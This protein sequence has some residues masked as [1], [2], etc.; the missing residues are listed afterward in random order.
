[1]TPDLDRIYLGDCVETMKTWPSGFVNTCVTSPPYWGL[2][3]YGVDGQRGSEPSPEEFVA[4][5]VD[6]FREV[7]RVLRDDGT[8]WLNIGD[9]YTD[10]GRGKD[11]GSTLDG[12][13]NNQSESRKIT[14]REKF[15]GLKPKNLVGIPW[16][17][18]FA[19]QADGWYLRSDIIWSKPNVMPE[20]A[21]DRPT[22]AHEYIF[23]LTKNEKYY[24]DQEAILEDCSPNT[25][26]R[27]SQNVEAQIGSARAN[28]GT[29]TN[30]NM[31]AVVRSA[32]ALKNSPGSKQNENFASHVCLKVE[33][34]NKR[35][36]WTVPPMPFKEAHFATYPVDLISPCILAGSPQGGVVLDPFMG[37]GTTALASAIYSRRFI[38]CELNPEYISIAERRIKNET[39]QGKFL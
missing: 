39:D 28:G 27:V 30:G 22:K 34:R 14:V 12:T 36:V 8:L 23:L 20:S 18:A 19:L 37:A 35:T 16:R 4:G 24:Y 6:V 26:A 25:H 9:S 21:I 29:K 38:G 13:R 33:K 3:D 11:V 32:K 1:M 5:M 2:R 17:L 7:G 15:K 31:K 10:G